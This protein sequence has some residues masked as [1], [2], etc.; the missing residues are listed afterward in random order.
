MEAILITGA[1]GFI[2]AH[3]AARFVDENKYRLVLTDSV[4][5]S[6][7][8]RVKHPGGAIAIKA[9]LRIAEEMIRV[10]SAS[11]PLKAVFLFHGIMSSGSEASPGLSEEV[12]LD[13]TRSLLRF[14]A[15]ETRG[16][17]VVYA[18]S[19]AVYGPPLPAVVT[20][21]TTPTPLGTYGT[22]KF[23][24]E[25]YIN[26]MHRRGDIDAFSL[27]FPTITVRPGKPTQAA[28]SFLSGMI[29]EP[30]NGQ[31]SVIPILDRSFKGWLC[32]PKTLVEN[33]VL[34]LELPGDVLPLHKRALNMPGIVATIQ[35]MRDALARVGGKDK[36]TFLREEEDPDAK[37]LLESWPGE[38]DVSTALKLG[39][40][41]DQSF[42]NI[43]REYVATLGT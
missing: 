28:S 35:E 13:A 41:Q 23:M 29:R 20:D 4:L 27:R 30:M 31:E 40:A 11:K 5:P 14:L 17:R 26:E 25:L 3:L 19:V 8:A 34:V 10:V 1:A 24:T 21:A 18:S 2:G 32:G 42:E 7:P 36:L 39:L 43:V 15:E 37:A 22:H 16:V 6:V 33:L 9:D 12:N 38:V